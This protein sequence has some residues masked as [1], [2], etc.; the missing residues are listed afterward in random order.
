LR[1]V[2]PF[3]A[4]TL[5]VRSPV[6]ETPVKVLEVI[7]ELA[8]YRGNEEAVIERL[9]LSMEATLRF[10]QVAMTTRDSLDR[11]SR[12]M[13]LV[14]E[15][16]P[17]LMIIFPARKADTVIDAADEIV[18]ALRAVEEVASKRRQEVDLEARG[19]I[20]SKNERAKLDSVI[21]IFASRVQLELGRV[22]FWRNIL[23]QP[24]R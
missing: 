10:R 9:R 17:R 7:E 1:T 19:K 23:T 22:G 14:V 21:R 20:S 12:L 16:I 15:R 4:T 18:K 2:A 6:E 8:S 5:D 24:R 3:L 13:T 11:V